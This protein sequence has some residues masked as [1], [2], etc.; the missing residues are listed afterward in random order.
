ML[1]PYLMKIGN[2][3][4]FLT[5]FFKN[6]E[7]LGYFQVKCKSCKDK[8]RLTNELNRSLRR[9]SENKISPVGDLFVRTNETE[10]K[11][12]KVK[13]CNDLEIEDIEEY[14]ISMVGD[15]F[16]P[17]NEAE[18]RES[19]VNVR[20]DLAIK[21]DIEHNDYDDDILKIEQIVCIF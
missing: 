14:Q 1:L 5:L 8:Y 18:F 17:I 19:K 2:C 6:K 13:I 20:D 16:V 9:T 7:V 12:V 4:I 10:M 3:I 21:E 15:M 11:E